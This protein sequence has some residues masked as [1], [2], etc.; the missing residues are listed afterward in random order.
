MLKER[1]AWNEATSEANASFWATR[2]R[3][4]KKAQRAHKGFDD[5]YRLEY[6]DDS[7]RQYA[8]HGN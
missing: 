1:G 3:R 8:Q 4:L 5:S 6:F 7:Y 2:L